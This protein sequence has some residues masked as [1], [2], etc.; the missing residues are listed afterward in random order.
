MVSLYA[1]KYNLVQLKSILENIGSI[2]VINVFST[3]LQN[4]LLGLFSANLKLSF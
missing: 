4:F 1:S 3:C 2:H